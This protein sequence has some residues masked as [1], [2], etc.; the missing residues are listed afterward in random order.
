MEFISIGRNC[1]VAY[2]INRF[3]KRKETNFFDWLMTD[4]ETVNKLLSPAS[5][6]TLISKD[7][8]IIDNNYRCGRNV[9]VTVNSLSHMVSIHDL[10]SRHTDKDIE[11][12]LKK[13]KRRYERLV[14]LINNSS[15]IVFIRKDTNKLISDSEINGFIE[16]VYKINPNSSFNLVE[17]SEKQREKSENG[18][19][20]M[21]P[22]HV[23][24]NLLRYK[25]DES[26]HRKGD[27]TTV[28]L[29]NWREIFDEIIRLCRDGTKKTISE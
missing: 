23:F 15:H 3:I 29:Y 21:S 22:E 17:L 20:V 1:S 14:H 28:S 4:M 25:F 6:D 26:K 10:P 13:Y 2:C 11:N 19:N 7:H 8:L 9:K 5:I 18:D 24:I 12:F 16:N 27:W